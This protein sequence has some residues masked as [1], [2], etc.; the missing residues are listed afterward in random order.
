MTVD[1]AVVVGVAYELFSGDGDL[2]SDTG[3]RSTA[4]GGGEKVG[5]VNLVALGTSVSSF[6]GRRT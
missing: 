3:S 6:T 4:G 1:K 2:C 5:E